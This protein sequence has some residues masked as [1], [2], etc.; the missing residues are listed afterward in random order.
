MSRRF[1]ALI[2][3]CFCAA[4]TWA[5]DCTI[6]PGDC[7]YFWLSTDD[8]FVPS[9]LPDDPAKV[10]EFY[11]F[12][13][14]LGGSIYIWARPEVGQTLKNWSLNLVVSNNSIINSMSSVV[15]KNDVTGAT[16]WQS[17]GEPTTTS[18]Q[19][20]NIAGLKQTNVGQGI[21]PA[22]QSTDKYYNSAHTAWL[23]ARV[24]Y[25]LKS[26]TGF[27]T[28]DLFLQIGSL[29]MTNT[30]GTTSD[31]DAIFG[32]DDDISLNAG[33][34]MTGGQRQMSSTFRDGVIKYFAKPDADFDD[35][36]IVNG[37]DFLRW[38]RK[39][40]ITT[41]DD[42]Q[43]NANAGCCIATTG[44]DDQVNG[45]DLAAWRYQYGSIVNPTIVELLQSVPEPNSLGLALCAVFGVFV[46]C[47]PPRDTHI[48]NNSKRLGLIS[49]LRRIQSLLPLVCEGG[50]S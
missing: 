34:S 24:D 41:L 40:G 39:R 3:V 26:F 23:M 31:V 48:V 19:L 13:G 27:A 7:T 50:E 2:L 5:V 49:P 45:I 28:S 16:R 38:Q 36:T 35:N 30:T 44:L 20:K 29:G 21:G 25:T 37:R 11:N 17:W 42:T 1:C 47:R 10:P 9:P 8:F 32:H 33:N 46:A 14:Q 43:G 15:Y 4:P 6:S 22:T 18:T 12:Q